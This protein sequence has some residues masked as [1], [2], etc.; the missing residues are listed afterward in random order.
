MG[1]QAVLLPDS[2][3]GVVAHHRP[4]VS[5]QVGHDKADAGEQ[6]AKVELNL[7]HHHPRRAADRPGLHFRA[8]GLSAS[9]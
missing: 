3:H 2:L 6:L 7:R 4:V 8:F 9:A 1:L 5:R